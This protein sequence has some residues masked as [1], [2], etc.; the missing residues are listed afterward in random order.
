[1]SEIML[2]K[3][4]L[5]FIFAAFAGVFWGTN[6][7]FCAILSR[8]GLSTVNIAILA[9]ASN[10]LFFFFALLFFNR[11]GFRVGWKSVALL[12]T[13][14]LLAAIINVSFVKSISYFPVGIVSTLVFCNVFVIMILSRIFFKNKITARK[15]FAAITALIGIA[16]V[17]NVFSQGFKVNSY[18]LLW[19]L[20][21][22]LLWAFMVTIEKYL[23]D[24]GLGSD[25]LLMYMGFFAVFFLSLISPPWSLVGNIVE[26]ISKNN[27]LVLLFILGYGIIPQV[28]SYAFYMQAL[29]YLEPSYTQIAFS[30]DPVTAS[31]LGYFVFHQTMVITQVIGIIIILIVVA[32]IQIMENQEGLAEANS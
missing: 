25:T 14:G 11:S 15:I 2:S 3:K 23:I 1:M 30:L 12:A 16:M 20:S 32:Y 29:K 9:P 7:T 17:L 13:D 21:T 10:F 31:I 5:G 6:G 18:G 4:G 26:V 8:F 24:Q 19:I 28:G 22:I 27:C